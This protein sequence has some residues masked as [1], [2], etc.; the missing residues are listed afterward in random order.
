MQVLVTE[1][2]WKDGLD[3]LTKIADVYYDDSLWNKHEEL[4]EKVKDVDGIII[5]NQTKI[6]PLLLEKAKRLKVI[7]RLGV[8]LDNIDIQACKEKGITVVYAQNANA[9]SVAEYVMSA[10]LSFRRNLYEADISVKQGNWDRRH[11]TGYEVYGKT[12]GLVGVGEIAHRI[13]KRALP[14]GLEVLGYDPFRSSYDF[15]VAETGIQLASIDELLTKSDYVSI[16]VPL[17][18]STQNMFNLETLKLMKSSSCLINTSRGGII[19]E[20]AL[21]IALDSH[22][23]AGAYLDVLNAEPPAKDNKLLT[24]NK[25]IFTPHIAGL[26]EESQVRTSILV[27]DEVLK[28]LN[29][30]SP[31]FA[32]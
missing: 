18:E 19:D 7:G 30:E 11:H 13:A 28:V 16:H 3:R 31:L 14:F 21:N 24:N 23:I 12:L 20:D 9:I 29:G 22:Y 25:A 4:H 32:V 2:I 15:Q 8:G 27:A 17:L 5:R 10:I 26:T 1:L 6:T